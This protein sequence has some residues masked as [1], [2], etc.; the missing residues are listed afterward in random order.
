MRSNRKPPCPRQRQRGFTLIEVMTAGVTLSILTLGLVGLWSTAGGAVN[1]LVIREKAIWA[2]NG[3]MERLAALY[4][5]T[6]FGAGGPDATSGYGYPAAYSDTRLIF[7]QG[8]LDLIAPSGTLLGG[9]LG[10]EEDYGFLE[11]EADFA[12]AEGHPVVLESALAPAADRNYVWIDRDQGIVGRLSW[13]EVAIVVDECGPDNAPGGSEPCLCAD[14][15]GGGAAERCLEIMLS[16][17]FP[18]RWNAATGTAVA[19]PQAPEILSLRTI[20]GRGA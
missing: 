9:L 6:D 19:M 10:T 1:D 3:Q 15:G 14:F 17:E 5:F 20:V 4:Q 11:N 13:E 12:A 16:L 7:G 8:L 2:L 18:F